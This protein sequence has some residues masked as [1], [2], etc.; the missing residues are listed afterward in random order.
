MKVTWVKEKNMAEPKEEL[1]ECSDH[2]VF[3]ASNELDTK[4]NLAKCPKCKRI[5]ILAMPVAMDVE[6]TNKCSASCL[7]C[8]RALPTFDREIGDMTPMLLGRIAA[9]I[10]KWNYK[11]HGTIRWLWNHL[12]GEPLIHPYAVSYIN[13]LA[14]A[15]GQGKVNIALSTNAIPLTENVAKEILAS[16][17][18]RLILSVD[19]VSAKTYEKIR[20]MN[21]KTMQRNVDALLSIARQREAKQLKNPQIWLQILKMEEN[22]DEWLKFVRRY[23]G[24]PRIT[25]IKKYRDIKDLTHGRVFVKNV[26]RFGGQVDTEHHPGWDGA[27]NRRATCMKPWNRLSIFW[28]GQVGVCCYDIRGLVIVG[29]LGEDGTKN[30][31][32]GV[33]HGPAMQSLR[34]EMMEWQKSRG[35]KGGLPELCVNC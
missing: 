30:S 27:D 1:F 2:G 14:N 28:D 20:G 8:P 24:M 31:I 21:F 34:A 17:L 22:E 25:S 18:H 29:N 23:S 3:V 7:M 10:K 15:T 16:D 35:E 32:H 11:R 19:G 13:Q 33:W 6:T 5:C 9:E 4:R 26:E 12:A